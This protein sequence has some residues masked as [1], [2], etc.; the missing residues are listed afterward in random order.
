MFLTKKEPTMQTSFP[1]TTHFHAKEHAK[2]SCPCKVQQYGAFISTQL[3]PPK[4]HARAYKNDTKTYLSPTFGKTD[5]HCAIPCKAKLKSIQLHAHGSS[6]SHAK[7]STQK[8]YSMQNIHVMQAWNMQ[9][10]TLAYCDELFHAEQ[11]T[12]KTPPCEHIANARPTL[13]KTKM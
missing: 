3:H 11:M 12:N 1:C 8:K 13:N 10:Q 5:S 7:L 9:R 6:S 2:N 4:H